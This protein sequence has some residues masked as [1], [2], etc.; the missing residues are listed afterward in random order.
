MFL[1]QQDI[2]DLQL[3]YTSNQSTTP[4]RS[5]NVFSINIIII[6][7]PHMSTT[8]FVFL[9]LSSVLLVLVHTFVSSFIAAAAAKQTAI[10]SLL[11]PCE[12][13]LFPVL[14]LGTCCCLLLIPSV[15]DPT[16]QGDRCPLDSNYIVAEKCVYVNQQTL[17]LQECPEDVPTGEMPRHIMCIAERHLVDRIVPGTRCSLVGYIDTFDQNKQV[18]F[19]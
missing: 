19:E 11:L 15:I 2:D 12:R 4:I 5:I 7:R 3:L 14:V 16:V 6:I 17:K 9:V 10:P 13:F 1:P 8:S 18:G